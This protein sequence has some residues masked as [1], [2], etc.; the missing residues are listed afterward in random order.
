MWG[1]LERIKEAGYSMI[2]NS[3]FDCDSSNNITVMTVSYGPLH[4]SC[5][6]ITAF[7]TPLPAGMDRLH[8]GNNLLSALPRLPVV[9]DK[10]VCRNTNLASLPELPVRLTILDFCNNPLNEL[11]TTPIGELD[12]KSHKNLLS[13]LSPLP[14]TIVVSNTTNQ[15]T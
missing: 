10:Q 11:P 3:N 14:A 7:P 5:H 1:T 6:Q 15:G 8:C 12:L 13:K 4:C 9:L 2:R